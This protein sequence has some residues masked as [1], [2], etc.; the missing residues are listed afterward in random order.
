MIVLNRQKI[1]YVIESEQNLPVEKQSVFILVPI[2]AKDFSEVQD[3]LVIENQGKKNATVKNINSHSYD[4][5]RL[6]LAGWK[7]VKD[8][9]GKEIKFDTEEKDAMIDMIPIGIRYELS[10]VI[11]DI[12]FINDDV[13]KK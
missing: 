13:K 11:S 4:L 6:G 5:L 2:S 7:N 12:T 3:R 8:A 1:E 9:D 10:N